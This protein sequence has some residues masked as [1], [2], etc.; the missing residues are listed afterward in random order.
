[1]TA[2][3]GETIVPTLD[4]ATIVISEAGG[5]VVIRTFGQGFW[6]NAGGGY[7]GMSTLELIEAL[8]TDD[9]PLMIGKPG[10]MLVFPDGTEECIIVRLPTGGTPTSFPANFPGAE[11]QDDCET[12]YSLPTMNRKSP[13]YRNVLLGQTISLALNIRL[14]PGMSGTSLCSGLGMGSQVRTA[15]FRL[16]L[17]ETAGGALE[18]ANRALAGYTD[19]GGVSFSQINDCVTAINERFS[20][21]GSSYEAA[22]QHQA[23]N[24]SLE[25]RVL[26]QNFPNPFKTE[27]TISVNMDEGGEAAVLVFD[28]S[29]RLL[30]TLWQGYLISGPHDFVWDGKT[31]EGVDVQSGVFFYTLTT[32]NKREARRMLVIR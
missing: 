22:A 5:P 1:M 17:P 26:L 23:P 24:P 10:K 15:L 27:T 19:L 3:G 11:V 31:E 14:N 13:R 30:R 28:A 18:L 8:I 21:C 6:G 32:G 4:E 9:N 16:G 2:C 12:S 7:K 29:G 20:S 25:P